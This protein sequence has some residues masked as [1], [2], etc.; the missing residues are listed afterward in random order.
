MINN[1]NSYGIY[2]TNQ[3]SI[4][5]YDHKSWSQKY[6]DGKVKLEDLYLHKSWKPIFNKIRT[7]NPKKWENLNNALSECLSNGEN[8]F[9]YPDLI[10][11]GF[12]KTP[13]DK[14]KVVIIGMDPY[15]NQRNINS[16]NIPEAMGLSFSVPKGI[17]IPSSLKNIFSNAVKNKQMYKYPSHGNLDFW[18]YQGCLMINTALT[19]VQKMPGSHA[20]LW[21][22]L[23]NEICKEISDQHPA[24]VFVLWGSPAFERSRF[25]DTTKH[26]CVISSHPSGLSCYKPM[27]E[28]PAFSDC[29]HFGKINEYLVRNNKTKIIWQIA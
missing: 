22:W 10:F 20:S 4:N 1:D 17:P 9:P 21:N 25:I 8:I 2:M 5:N 16:K 29:N 27:K 15:F 3:L 6:P 26:N 19:V 7:N 12:N 11:D 24:L 18:A 23:T 14:I 28:F 13:F